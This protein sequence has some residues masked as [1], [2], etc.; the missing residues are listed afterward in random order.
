[1]NREQRRAVEHGEGPLLVLS[2]AGSGKTRVH[3]H[4]IAHQLRSGRARAPHILAVTFTNKAAGEMRE[5]L[6]RLAGGCSSDVL[7][8][9]FHSICAR[10]L[11]DHIEAL[12]LGYRAS[13]VIYDGHDQLGLLSSALEGRSLPL[14]PQA[15][16]ARIDQAKNEARRPDELRALA[17][18]SLEAA[19]AEG[20]ALYQE[21]LRR[22]NALDFGDLLL[23]ALELLERIPELR[24]R[25]QDRW[26]HLLV[27]EYQDTNRVQYLWLKALAARHRN[28]CAVG[29]EDQSIYGWRGADIRNILD[30]EKD[31]PDAVVVRLEQNYRSTQSILAAAGA[32]IRNNRDRKGKTLWTAN[33]PGP[34]TVLHHARDEHDEARFVIQEVARASRQRPLGDFVVFYR[35]NAQ[36]RVFEEECL[37]AGIGYSLVGGTKFYER[38]EIKDV[39]AYLRVIANPDD[40][41]SLLRVINVPARGIGASTVAKLVAVARNRGGSLFDALASPLESLSAGARA[42]VAEFAA[43]LAALREHAGSGGIGALVEQLFRLTGYLEALAA[44]A[45]ADAESR[46]EDLRELVTVA[47]EADGEGRNLADFLAQIALVAEADSLGEGRDRLTLM[48][49]HTSKGLEFPVVFLVGMEEGL[50]PHRRSLDDRGSVE[51]ERRLC[52]VGMTRAREQLF[53][54]RARRRHL[55]GAAAENPPS[56]FLSEIPG[57]LLETR[58]PDREPQRRV[59]DYGESQ[60][61]AP[62]AAFRVGTRVRHPTL[63]DGV[64]RAVEGHGEREKVTVMFGGFGIRK[65][66]VAVARLETI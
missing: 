27:D 65:L 47:Q 58:E 49:L 10:L 26:R 17:E 43:V 50:F 56:R 35:T 29:D 39:L 16:L 25:Y 5:R 31:Y 53:L 2:G 51:E 15:L 36:S 23:L 8:G 33:P 30:F 46:L 18:T 9:T 6:G 41:W 22:N 61:D 7:M 38:K 45:A 62:R 3:T 59:I 57:E 55:F 66:A 40:E 52:Y 13:F 12:K 28:L 63:G 24:D 34:R 64:V 54:S 14:A 32:V 21:A 19:A 20:Y 1:M 11:R 48:T 42:K 4:R 44:R 60:L 37:R